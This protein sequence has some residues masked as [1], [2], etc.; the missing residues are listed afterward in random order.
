MTSLDT[1]VDDVVQWALSREDVRAVW[2]EGHHRAS[3]RRPYEDIELHIAVD[4]PDFNT[5]LDAL[6]KSPEGMAGSVVGDVSE[7]HCRALQL[8]LE[9]HGVK[10]TLILERTS[11]LAKRPRAYVATLLDRTG[12]LTH[13]MDTSLR[14][15]DG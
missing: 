3:V 12:H 8:Q 9:A 11:M 6:S 4:E 14:N 1:V 5:V 2:I 10:W 7:T 13:V 15:A